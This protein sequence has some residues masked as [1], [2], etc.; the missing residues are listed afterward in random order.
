MTLPNETLVILV[1]TSLGLNVL[2]LVVLAFVGRRR[3]TREPA[4]PIGLDPIVRGVFEDQ[5][6][7]IQRVEQAIRA[8]HASAKRQE[9]LIHDGVRNAG[10]VRY[11]AFEDVGGRLSFSCALLDDR[12]SGVVLTSINGRQDTRVYAKPI[13]GGSSPYNLSTEEE[14]AIRQA[15]AGPRETVRAT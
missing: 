14:E 8:L 13:A 10:M 7:S 11:D 4:E 2:A 9:S 6:Q 5:Q 15:L 3:K 1:F 12:G